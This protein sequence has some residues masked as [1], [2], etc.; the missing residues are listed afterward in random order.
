MSGKPDK[1]DTTCLDV[2]LSEKT[3]GNAHPE[4]P[5][6]PISNSNCRYL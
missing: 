3:V 2:R 5:Y 4:N 1:V 6:H